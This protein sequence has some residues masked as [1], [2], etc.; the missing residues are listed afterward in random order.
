MADRKVT[1]LIN[2]NLSNFSKG[3]AKAQANLR[4]FGSNMKSIGRSMTT[5]VTTPLLLAGG[6][7]IKMAVDFQTSMTKINTLVGLTADRVNAMTKDVMG[8]SDQTGI[9]S[10][11]LA[12]ALFVV[13]SAG[14]RG[15]EAM[16]I[17]DRSAKASAI[18]LGEPK[19]LQEQLLLF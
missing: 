11:E 4:Q 9:S 16:Q 8:L 13:T 19:I 1:F 7:S 17:L 12:D 10:K 2:A 15:A 18:G 14:Q 6:A 3:L 5:Y